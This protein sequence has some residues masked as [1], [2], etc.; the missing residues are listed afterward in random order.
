MDKNRLMN[1]LL[2][3]SFLPSKCQGHNSTDM[4]VWPVDMHIQ[5]ELFADGLDILKAFLEIGACAADPNLDFMLNESWCELS[6]STN[7]TLER[8]RDLATR[9]AKDEFY[10]S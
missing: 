10:M 3:V 6:Q 8:R 5:F 1:K 9:L 4:H 2:N 7:H